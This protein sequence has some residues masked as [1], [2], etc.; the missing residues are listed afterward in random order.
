MRVLILIIPLLLFGCGDTEEPAAIQ[1]QAEAKADT[2]KELTTLQKAEAGDSQAQFHLGNSYNIGRGV[3]KS[4]N[5]A[6]IWYQKAAKQGHAWA[7]VNLGAMYYLGDGVP[8]DD[9]QAVVWTQKAADQGDDWGQTN[10]GDMYANG[11]GV[12]QDD[13]QAFIWYQKAAEQGNVWAQGNLGYMYFYGK[14]VPED[15]KQAV[16][17]YQKAAKQSHAKAV[18]WYQRAAK[19]S[20]TKYVQAQVAKKGIATAQGNLGTMYYFGKGVSRDIVTAYMW[21]NIAA[22]N[23][24]EEATEDREILNQEMPKAQIAEAQRR[25]QKCLDGNYQDC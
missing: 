20:Y 22:T 24:D 23:G 25:S 6:A 2:T 5:Q 15:D 13:K 7:Q 3:P 1:Q 11:E 4:E 12:P 14:G 10:L 17:W 18:A 16:A 19:Q 9:K 8:Q 21:F